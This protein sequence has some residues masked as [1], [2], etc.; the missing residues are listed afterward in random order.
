MD[1]N[2]LMKQA[3]RVQKQFEEAQAKMNET[4][5]TGEAGGGLVRMN[6]KG[7]G[8]ITSLT[9]D[10]SLMTPSEADML[11]DLIR[12]AH[13]DARRKLEAVNA[14]LMKAAAGPL[15]EMGGLPPMPK[16]FQG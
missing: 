14:E 4:L 10:P 11:S 15:G 9:I 6:M 1:F 12:A 16:F 13:A 3:Q 5:V 7:V 2:A 8:D